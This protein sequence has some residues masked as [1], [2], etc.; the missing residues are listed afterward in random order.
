MKGLLYEHLYEVQD[1]IMSV[2]RVDVWPGSICQWFWL[3]INMQV[4]GD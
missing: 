3:Y 1:V 2:L 4:N